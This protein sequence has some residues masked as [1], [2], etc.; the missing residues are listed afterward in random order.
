MF[1]GPSPPAAILAPSGTTAPGDEVRIGA[2]RQIVLATY[3]FSLSFQGGALLGV[4]VPA[5]L[6]TLVGNNNKTWV[7]GLVGGVAAFLGMV[8]QPI[9]GVLSDLSV[10][11]WGR[12]R[13]YLVGGALLDIA[14]LAL[15]IAA[16]NLALL[17][18][19]CTIAS[20]GG[21]ISGAAYQAYLP[22]HVPPS[23]YGIASGYVGALTMLGTV[24]SFGL[25]GALVSPTSA[26]PFYLATIAAIGAGALFTAVAIDD[27]VDAARQIY[28]GSLSWR[29]L[30]LDPWRHPDF[31]L[32]FATRSM[33]MLALYTLFTFVEYYMQDVV[34]VTQF[35]QGAAIVAG[36]ATVAALVGGIITGWL[37]D[38]TGRRPIVSGASVL[39]ASGLTI[40]AFLHSLNVVLGVGVLF[41]LALGAY[42]A[43]DWALAIDVLPDRAFAAKD[44]GLWGI[45]SNLP[46][47]LAPLVGGAVLLTLAP[48]GATVGFG[49]LF[50]GA[51]VCAAVSGLLVWRL[52]TV[53]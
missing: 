11:R 50:L 31:V 47:T 39:M 26:A 5:Q 44:L 34:R 3:W 14:G 43:V 8:A 25:A 13:P 7:L 49:V 30:W 20:V 1:D 52:R 33:M 4:A 23:Q 27:P 48:F 17:F 12:R 9:A 51:A 29:V 22:D 36:V 42:S 38:R 37:S 19:G 21:A 46:Q 53:R 10:T 15:M 28:H 6:L 24:A 41:G 18:L 2:R 45:S 32:V 35:V 16:G 40:L